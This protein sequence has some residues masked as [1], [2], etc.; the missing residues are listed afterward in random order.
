MLSALSWIPIIGPII[1]GLTSMF[2]KFQDKEI[3]KIQTQG[4]TDVE[5]MKASANIIDVTKDDIGV[6]LSRDVLIFP[7]A[8]WGGAYGWD[9]LVA[10]HWP[11]LK[12]G[13]A[14]PPQAIAYL[15]Y[16]VVVFLLGNIG[17]NAWRRR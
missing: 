8:C 16:A 3:V 14:D 12:I 6:R 2:N 15:P 1:E 17:I 5:A 10:L 4:T 11:W 13:I 7:W 9:T